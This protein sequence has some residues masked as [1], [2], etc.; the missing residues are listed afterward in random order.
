VRRAAREPRRIVIFEF[1]EDRIE[2]LRDDARLS[3]EA[4]QDE[5]HAFLLRNL[6]WMPVRFAINGA[7]MLGS[8]R[9]SP[10][11]TIPG[12]QKLPVLGVALSV[13]GCPRE[14][15]HTGHSTTDP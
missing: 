13:V 4:M 6:F 14:A 2:L 8:D 7:E 12:W 11:E 15:W 9:G 1:E 5:R 3:P 10:P